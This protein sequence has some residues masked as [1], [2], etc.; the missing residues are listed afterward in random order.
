[1]SPKAKVAATVA[2]VACRLV[3]TVVRKTCWNVQT[4]D[5][6][7]LREMCDSSAAGFIQNMPCSPT[8]AVKQAIQKIY[9]SFQNG[10]IW[11]GTAQSSG[12]WG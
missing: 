6:S 2:K 12:L 7:R 11:A 4:E 10:G 9:N 3:R 5:S 1:M 8:D